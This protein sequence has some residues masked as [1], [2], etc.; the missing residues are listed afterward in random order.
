M[1]RI[2][3]R[4]VLGKGQI[5][6]PKVLRETLGIH[7]GDTVQIELEDDHLIIRKGVNP[8]DVF[9]EISSSSGTKITM[10]EIKKELESRYGED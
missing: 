5:V 7:E 1:V 4:H 8:V 3:I 6:I 9:R 2:T 10:K